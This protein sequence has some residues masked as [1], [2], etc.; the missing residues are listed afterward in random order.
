MRERIQE[1]AAETTAEALPSLPSVPTANELGLTLEAL[2]RAPLDADVA[3]LLNQ[4]LG[5]LPAS[6]DGGRLVLGMLSDGSLT[7]AADAQG[8]LCRAEAVKALLRLGFPWALEIDPETLAWFRS[9]EAPKK[10][11]WRRWALLAAG[12]LAASAGTA[13]WLSERAGD[14]GRVLVEPFEACVKASGQPLAADVLV[15]VTVAPTGMIRAMKVFDSTGTVPLELPAQ[16]CFLSTA[17]TMSSHL[18]YNG[19]VDVPLS[20]TPH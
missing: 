12:V 18:K 4:Q 20:A 1:P 15:R 5:V 2:R 7:G 3:A 14:E 17:R 11:S 8:R 19:V 10:T 16:S 13:A 9:H 6:D